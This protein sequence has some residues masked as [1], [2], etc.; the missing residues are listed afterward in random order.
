M[1]DLLYNLTVP[2]LNESIII[3]IHWSYLK[4]VRLL[5]LCFHSS[6]PRGSN[7]DQHGQFWSSLYFLNL[8]TLHRHS[9]RRFI[10]CGGSLALLTQTLKGNKY[11]LSQTRDTL[12]IISQ[13]LNGLFKYF[14]KPIAIQVPPYQISHSLIITK[15]AEAWFCIQL[16]KFLKK[17]HENAPFVNWINKLAV[18]GKLCLVF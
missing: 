10:V 16:R 1:K 11:N 5:K 3:C 18:Q 15:M 12:M 14:I 13:Y 4:K 7:A 8:V 2:K 9:F 6:H 17:F